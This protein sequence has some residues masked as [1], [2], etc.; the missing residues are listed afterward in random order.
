MSHVASGRGRTDAVRSPND[1]YRAV[2]RWHFYAGLLV[3]PFMIL[4]AV[5]GGIYLFKDEIND[6]AYARLRLVEPAPAPPL[7]PSAIVAAA[8]ATHPGTLKSYIPAA[9]PDRSAEVKIR[10][11]D[12]VRD[13]VYVDPYT[14]VVLG[15]AWDAGSSG[16]ELMW[17]VR[18]LHSLELV[19]WW[20]NRLVEAA[21][22]W[23]VL[24]VATGIFLWWPR[25][26]GVGVV[27]V[28]N[29]RGRPFWRDLHAVT[30]LYVGVFIVF[31]AITGLPW[32]GFWGKQFYDLSYEAGLG[33]PDGYWGKYPTSA[34]PTGTAL[35]RAPW[36]LE[37]QPMPVSGASAGVPAGLDQIVATVEARGIHP[38]Y[39]LDMPGGPEGVFT[40]SVYPDDVTQERVIHLDQY[41]GE[42]LFDMGLADL[43]TL[44]RAA[45]WGVSLHMGQAFGLANQLILLGACMAIVLLG[46]SGGVMWWR[47]RPAGS[48]GVPPLPLDRRV[49]AGLMA[50][51]V[52]GGLVFPLVGLSLA[53]M[54]LLDQIYVRARGRRRTSGLGAA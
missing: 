38:G 15:S 20:G 35:D 23:A 37:H 17:I 7:A 28:R 14:G 44:G 8:L 45:E 52:V 12:G 2:W 34:V 42:V 13:T 31:L 47:R 21:A 9:A 48:M 1:L 3:L 10:D 40:A 24:L 30:G 50:M 6:A 43:G 51:L 18:K 11:A 5:T 26:R 49:F 54:L 22:G 32:S 16:T 4:L 25:G 41:M 19:G 29:R 46:V 33:M 53:V 27:R 36:I 39:A